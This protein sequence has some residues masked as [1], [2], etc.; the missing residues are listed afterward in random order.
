L[1]QLSSNYHSSLSLRMNVLGLLMTKLMLFPAVPPSDADS[2][3]AL[4]W[5][6]DRW[7]LA[8][9][10]GKLL[11]GP[12]CVTLDA[13]VPSRDGAHQIPVRLYRPADVP[14]SAALPLVMYLH[15][16]GWCFGGLD[17]YD[18]VCRRLAACSRAV[19]C[20]VEYRLAP[21]FKFPRGLEDAHDA[22]TWCFEDCAML[23]ASPRTCGL[24]LAGDSAGGNLAAAL[25]VLVRASV[26]LRLQV[27][28]YPSTCAFGAPLWREPGARAAALPGDSMVQN[29]RAPALSQAVFSWFW[30]LY[31]ER[32][33][34]ASDP[35][36]SPMLTALPELQRVAP[37]LVLTA[38]A[39]PLLDEGLQYARRL[40]S[41][42]VPVEHVHFADGVHG[43][44]MVEQASHFAEAFDVMAEALRRAFAPGEPPPAGRL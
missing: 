44:V 40:R 37:A 22:L 8:A 4:Q 29:S 33:E 27:L 21:E 26:P 18:A 10:A 3:A 13:T 2:A 16:G 39:D 5:H 15:G 14:T 19:V 7:A 6:R 41:A 38:A 11:P 32:P 34:Q 30:A 20:S 23:G 12:A 35:R 17:N 36:A 31:L 1:G 24:A 28:I 25:A 42:G 9:R 43:L